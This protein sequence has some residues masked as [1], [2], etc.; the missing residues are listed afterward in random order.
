MEEITTT[1]EL[2]SGGTWDII[3]KPKW[4]RLKGIRA[5]EDPTELIAMLTSGWSFPEPVTVETIDEERDVEDV[6]AILQ[7]INTAVLPLLSALGE[8]ETKPTSES[9]S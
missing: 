2:P 3:V 5:T 8:V 1:I 9:K 7:A 6:I 4:G